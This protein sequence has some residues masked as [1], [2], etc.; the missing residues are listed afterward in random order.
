M[1]QKLSSTVIAG[2]MRGKKL[3]NPQKGTRPLTNR[4]KQSLFDLIKDFVENATILDL[5]AGGGNFGIE[6]LSRGAKHVTFVDISNNSINC[7]EENLTNIEA[8]SYELINERVQDYIR[9]TE[10]EFD[11]IMCDPPFDNVILTH[12]KDATKLLTPTGIFIFRHPTKFK[13]PKELYEI[14]RIYQQKY[15]IS[16][17]SFY[18]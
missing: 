8:D 1:A 17:I 16:T 12:I 18:R 7:I 11:I 6:A 10:K 15:G 3:K 4:I 13:S 2:S 9:E 5:Y 14:E